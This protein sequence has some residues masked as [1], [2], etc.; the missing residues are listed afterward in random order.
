MDIQI[1]D[2]S[3]GTRWDVTNPTE[4]E[5]WF[6]GAVLNG[7]LP[8]QG[9]A[10]DYTGND[11]SV[12]KFIPLWNSLWTKPSPREYTRWQTFETKFNGAPGSVRIANFMV[13]GRAMS[14]EQTPPAVID[15]VALFM[16]AD[17]PVIVRYGA[18]GAYAISEFDQARFLARYS[19]YDPGSIFFLSKKEEFK[20]RLRNRCPA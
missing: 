13:A 12:P 2:A 5:L 20:F 16:P 19:L 18:Y 15:R 1:V 8:P 7:T 17:M 14:I 11:I 10:L 6:I 3:P 4:H 9:Y